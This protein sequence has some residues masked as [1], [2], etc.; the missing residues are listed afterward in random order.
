MPTTGSGT[1]T[2]AVDGT[3]YQAGTINYDGIYL[4]GSFSAAVTFSIGATSI[5]NFDL[6]ASAGG[7]TGTSRVRKNRAHPVLGRASRAQGPHHPGLA[8]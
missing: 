6:T 1:Y 3:Y 4:S 8:V 5:G 7:H 2:G